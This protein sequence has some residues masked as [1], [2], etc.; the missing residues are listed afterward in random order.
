MCVSVCVSVRISMICVCL[1]LYVLCRNVHVSLFSS[2]LWVIRMEVASNL[3]VLFLSFSMPRMPIKFNGLLNTVN[4]SGHG[5]LPGTTPD[6]RQW[7]FGFWH[8]N[9]RLP[10]HSMPA[11]GDFDLLE[12]FYEWYLRILPL[13]RAQTAGT[14]NISNGGAAYFEETQTQFGSYEA[15]EYGWGCPSQDQHTPFATNAYIRFHWQGSLELLMQLTDDYTYSLNKTRAAKYTIPLATAILNFYEQRF[16]HSGTGLLDIFPTNS[17]ETWQCPDPSDRTL[18]P[19]NDAPTVAGLRWVLPKLLT[20][21][22]DVL[23]AGLRAQWRALLARV[24]EIPWGNTT[25]KGKPLY[26]VLFPAERTASK[27]D[28]SGGTSCPCNSE[29]TELYSIFPYRH[30][31][32][33]TQSSPMFTVANSSFNARRFPGNTGWDQDL[34]QAAFLGRTKEAQALAIDRFRPHQPEGWWYPAFLGPGPNTVPDGDHIG[35]FKSGLQYMLMQPNDTDDSVL[36]FPSW[37]TDEWDVSFTLHAPL[38]TTVRASCVSGV[39]TEFQVDP[40]E[41]QKDVVFMSRECRP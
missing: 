13:R 3:L 6:F 4:A 34:T 20:L 21:P 5:T 2:R 12:G 11:A 36:L 35:V 8:Q 33:A 14:L 40:P 9:T 17:L 15:G 32:V 30:H 38:N 29:N 1:S 22:S 19:T 31:T 16:G 27:A 26:N 18:C 10:Y 24:P 41:R 39:L 25:Y 7:G 23:S 37:P 28:G